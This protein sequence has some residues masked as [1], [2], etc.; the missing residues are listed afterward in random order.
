MSAPALVIFDCDGVLVDS[1]TVAAR[2][3]QRVLAD[4]GF[5]VPMPEILDRFAGASAE[6]FEAGIADVIGR[7]LEPGWDSAYHHWYA[8]AFRTE[9]RP[10]PGIRDALAGLRLP[11]CV[12]SN[13]GRT[14]IRETLTLTGLLEHFEGR[15]FS[16]EDVARGKP[17]PDVFLRAAECMGATPDQCVVVEDSPFGVQAARAA[18]MRVLAYAG[19][20]PA[21]RLTGAGTFVFDDMA[22]LAGLIDAL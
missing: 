15:I 21:Q 16:A 22:A 9:L 20:V 1:E 3:S 14:R 4:L 19:T 13:S 7:P 2:V 18:G 6:V 10:V 8:E 12:A 17:E 11:R 5:E